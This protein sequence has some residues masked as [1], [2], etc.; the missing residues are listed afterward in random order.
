[1]CSLCGLSL[2]GSLIISSVGLY[3][4]HQKNKQIENKIIELIKEHN[5]LLNNIIPP[6]QL[7][8]I[9]KPISNDE[10]CIEDMKESR[11]QFIK[12]DNYFK[13]K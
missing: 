5:D 7:V 9:S 10:L 11:Y 3:Y 6:T 1:M 13:S 4:Q 12:N 2:L 8:H